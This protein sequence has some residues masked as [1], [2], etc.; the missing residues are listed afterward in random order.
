MSYLGSN[1]VTGKG[2]QDNLAVAIGSSTKG[3]NR[4]G[5]YADDEG[6]H[7]VV[8]GQTIVSYSKEKVHVTSSESV[9]EKLLSEE[10]PTD[11]IYGKRGSE[12]V[13]IETPAPVIVKGDKGE[14]GKPGVV[15]AES[16]LVYDKKTSTLSVLVG[17]S[18]GTLCAGN[19]GRFKTRIADMPD[20]APSDNNLYCRFNKT[21]KSLSSLDIIKDAFSEKLK[22]VVSKSELGS[23]A[24]QQADSVDILGG[25]ATLD[26]LNVKDLSI[27]DGF[28]IHSEDG[29]AFK[30]RKATHKYFF[31][32]KLP[33]QT[34]LTK[35]LCINTE[36]GKVQLQFN[37]WGGNFNTTSS[38]DF[39]VNGNMSAIIA[40][41]AGLRVSGSVRL[42]CQNI[43]LGVTLEEKIDGILFV[44]RQ[45]GLIN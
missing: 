35:F 43:Y 13:K 30:F 45:I 40:D 29:V 42:P 25:K 21:W 14:D 15:K 41:I 4:T 33:M 3:E 32:T 38:D 28:E 5:L 23:L 2:A 19:D 34:G 18:P 9:I 17:T 26:E 37:P 7:I 24:Y 27:V 16:P 8:N 11:G 22:D 6:L 1:I 36:S 10:A 20:D 39:I 44:L 31:E 12:W